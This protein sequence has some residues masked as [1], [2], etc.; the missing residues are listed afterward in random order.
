MI[1]YHLSGQGELPLRDGAVL[2]DILRMPADEIDL[3][4]IRLAVLLT[5]PLTAGLL[6]AMAMAIG[7]AKERGR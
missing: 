5:L 6:M 1:A 7:T 4:R 2:A 3:R